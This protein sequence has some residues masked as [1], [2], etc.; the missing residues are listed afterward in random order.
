MRPRLGGIRVNLG[1]WLLAAL[2]V[3]LI[4]LVLVGWYAWETAHQTFETQR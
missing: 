3:A 4:A 1:R 2:A